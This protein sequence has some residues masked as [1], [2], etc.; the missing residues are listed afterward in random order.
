ML[1]RDQSPPQQAAMKT[2]YETIVPWVNVT[3][4]KSTG[5]NG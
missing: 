2:N 5:K 4:C 3:V 1:E